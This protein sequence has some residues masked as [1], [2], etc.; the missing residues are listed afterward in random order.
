MDVPVGRPWEGDKVVDGV[1]EVDFVIGG[2]G[3]TNGVA[4]PL[5]PPPPPPRRTPP[6]PG[7]RE[8]E[9]LRDPPPPPPNR[10]SADIEGLGEI[11]PPPA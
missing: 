2:E 5:P 4:V 11:V 3:V 10:D 1:K 7:V 9:P 6:P 8:G